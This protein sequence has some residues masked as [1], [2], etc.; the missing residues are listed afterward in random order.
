MRYTTRCTS[1]VF[2]VASA[3]EAEINTALWDMWLGKDLT[4]LFR[5][6]VDED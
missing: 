1:L 6:K 4:L 5:E 2:V 3:G